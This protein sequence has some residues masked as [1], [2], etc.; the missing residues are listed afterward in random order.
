[1]K[2]KL[3]HDIEIVSA[4]PDAENPTLRRTTKIGR[5]D[6]CPCGSGKKAK[7]CCGI[8]P[9]YTYTKYRPHVTREGDMKKF[10]KH[11]PFAVGEIVLAS[12]AF[13]VEAF[14]GKELV[15]M[16]RGMEERFGN[17]YF[18]VAPVSDPDH[19]VDTS[20]W[21]SDGHLVKPEHYDQD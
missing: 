3:D 13:P 20:L 16:E 10:R 2:K 8:H 1:M 9:E 12:K 15:V 19:L 21:Y 18:K 14:R 11:I 5:N 6:P 7:N 4:L 17:F